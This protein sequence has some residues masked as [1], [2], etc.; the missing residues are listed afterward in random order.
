MSRRFC[1]EEE[2]LYQETHGHLCEV[3][4]TRTVRYRAQY[5]GHA[6]CADCRRRIARLAPWVDPHTQ[7][8]PE[9][10]HHTRSA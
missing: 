5:E 2:A 10:A 9:P 1:D 4:G 8:E 7:A 6:V 3:C